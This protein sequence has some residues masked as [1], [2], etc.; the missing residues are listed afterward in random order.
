MTRLPLLLVLLT[1]AGCGCDTTS[2][3]Y[4]WPQP[5]YG[6]APPVSFLVRYSEMY[7]SDEDVRA[8]IA[9][10]C[11]P[12]TEVARMFASDNR[13][14]LLHPQQS[15]VICGPA[16][17]PKASFR[18]QEIDPGRLISLKPAPAPLNRQ[19]R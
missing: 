9:E 1:V 3:P 15:L 2:L 12:Q 10:T 7:N 18:G 16:A 13:G 19:C 8:T 6:E 11:G 4:I 14:P 5:V 17:E